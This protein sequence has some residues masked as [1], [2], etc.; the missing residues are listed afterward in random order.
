MSANS[1]HSWKAP[2]LEE[3]AYTP[4][5]PS[6]RPDFDLVDNRA[7]AHSWDG[8]LGFAEIKVAASE[9]K[10]PQEKR[11]TY[12]KPAVLQ[13]ADYARFHLACRH[14][15][16]FTVVLLITG[17]DFR[18]MIIDHAGV[19]L[20]PLHSIISDNR[21]SQTP[22]D[23]TTFVRVVRAL[24]RLLGEA[25]LG[26]DPSVSLVPRLELQSYIQRSAD[27]TLIPDAVK[28][29]VLQPNEQS[30]HKYPSYLIRIHGTAGMTRIWCTMGPPIWVSLSL[31][32]RAT[33][34]W[35]AVEVIW[36]GQGYSLSGHARVL[37]SSWR[38][39]RR[40]READVYAAIGALKDCPKGIP[41]MLCGGDVYYE[42]PGTLKRLTTAA[43]RGEAEGD[44]SR[45]LHRL[46]LSIVGEPLWKYKDDLR[47]LRAFR[48]IVESG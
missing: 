46:V 9:N 20:S 8:C 33:T 23:A 15:W 16:I 4:G 45:V 6:M 3:E 34:V 14:F 17:T 35:R 12:V 32:G 37:K 2:G 10:K 11:N 18:V 43:I 29:A 1:P 26:Q 7:N 5:F 40:S 42:L 28:A 36:R 22:R 27:P 24:T 38:D 30:Y 13:C 44:G 47:L 39:P 31:L 19:I 25:D 48:D 21:A 41:Q